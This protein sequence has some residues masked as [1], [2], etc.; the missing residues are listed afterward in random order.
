MSHTMYHGS[1]VSLRRCHQ[2]GHRVKCFGIR[3]A[4]ET[5]EPEVRANTNSSEC[6]DCRLERKNE[7]T[8]CLT[9]RRVR[10]FQRLVGQVVMSNMLWPPV[11][12]K[13]AQVTR[14]WCPGMQVAN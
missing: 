1:Q 6:S 9:S 10:G 12:M 4:R 7:F 2:R 8:L 5:T 11:S 13:L 3:T 14:K